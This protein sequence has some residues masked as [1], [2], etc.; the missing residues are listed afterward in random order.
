MEPA[1]LFSELLD[2]AALFAALLCTFPR[3]MAR[4]NLMEETD[5][6]CG[7]KTRDGSTCER[8]TGCPCHKTEPAE[9]SYVEGA[10]RGGPLPFQD[11]FCYPIRATLCR[12]V[13]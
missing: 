7:A 2:A 11:A 3:A 13:V 10:F 9:L 6:I 12:V 4:G 5:D 8:P 1:A